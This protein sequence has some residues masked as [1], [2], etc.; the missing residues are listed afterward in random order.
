MENKEIQE[1]RVRRYFI[2][3]CKKI[4]RGEGVAGVSVRNVSDDAGYSFATLYNYFKDIYAL[5]NVCI[6]EFIDEVSEFITKEVK[7]T[8]SPRE[9]VVAKSWAYAKYFIQY[10]G[11]Y[12][13]LYLERLGVIGYNPAVSQKTESLIISAISAE[14]DTIY[15]AKTPE[16]AHLLKNMYSS[17]LH[18]Y[19]LMYLNKRIPVDFMEF[20]KSF[21]DSTERFLE[22]SW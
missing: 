13:L 21:N 2:E 12:E 4:I 16:E 6:D 5:M 10:P 8:S 3:S 22:M 15:S 18:G 11:I 20:R 1:E 19:L 9:A 17:M 7:D 14:F